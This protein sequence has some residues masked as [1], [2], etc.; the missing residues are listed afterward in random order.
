MKKLILLFAL[1]VSLLP[2]AAV[3][4]LDEAFPMTQSDG[5]VIMV[6]LFGEWRT[7]FYITTDGQ[8]LVRD[9]NK[10]LCY[11]RLEDGK[12]VSTGLMAHE[13][14]LRTQEER[15]FVVRNTLTPSLAATTVTPMHPAT[16]RHAPR[17]V[18]QASTS[19]GLGQYGVRSLGAVPSLGE[20][21]IPVIMVEFSD[22]KFQSYSTIEKMNR[23]YNEEGYADESGCV[24][25]V[26]DYFIAQSGGLFRPRFE[27]VSKLSLSRTAAYY[28]NNDN[29]RG[30]V[31][32]VRDAM[33]AATRLGVK[34]TNYVQDGAVPLVAVLYAGEGEATGGGDDTLWPCEYDVNTT[35]SGVHVN[36]LF[37]GNEM[38]HD[39]TI[40]GM[41]TFCHEFGHALGLPDFYV[42]DYGHNATTMGRWD[43]MCSG[44]YLPDSHARAPIGYTAYER[45]YMGWLDIP[46]LTEA[47]NIV[48][49]PYGSED[50][51]HAVLIRSN[52]DER[53]YFI[54]EHR[55][56]G[57]WYPSS[58][59]SGLFVSHVT[60]DAS[61]WRYNNL[62]NNADYLRMTYLSASG[63]KSGGN[64]SELFPGTSNAKTSITTTTTPALAL[65][66]GSRL[67]KPVYNITRE[68]DG[69][70]SFSYLDPDFVGRTVGD[71]VEAGGISYRF[72]TKAQ[73]EVKPRE[74]GSAYSGDLTIPEAYVDNT[75]RY[76]VAGVG[77]E[78]FAD[79]PQLT[80]L[81]LPTTLRSV[82]PDA[83]RRSPALQSVSISGENDRFV[84]L[85]GVLYTNS[86]MVTD[87][88]TAV[89]PVVEDNVFDFASNPWNL[90]VAT[91]SLKIDGGL[92]DEDLIVGRVTMTATTQDAD[93]KTLVYMLSSGGSTELRL[94]KGSDV[95]FT[96]P[97]DTRI[98]RIDFPANGWTAT[99]SVGTM[100]GTA[101]TGQA[102]S[103]KFD[104]TANSRLTTLHVTTVSR[105]DFKEAAL[106]YY[107][108]ARTGT[109]TVT[110]GVSRIG[111]Y[112]FEGTALTAVVLPD[113][114]LTL[115]ADALSSAAL[116]SITARRATPAVAE[117]DP[118]T[119]VDKHACTLIV[120]D[121][122]AD[123]YRSA[124]YWAAFFDPDG[125]SE[126]LPLV[127]R[128][129]STIYDL[130][131]RRL[132]REPQLGV[133]IRDGKKVVKSR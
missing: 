72:V 4:P 104:I 114:L 57:T 124:P 126:G 111:D 92:L 67:D 18:I 8:V 117:D 23:F 91:N 63:S 86:I 85:D 6:K 36:S 71:V 105:R 119:L 131:G 35:M 11:A 55:A 70:V 49:G 24:G 59:G 20:V 2:A 16:G 47:D 125:I 101:W 29:T 133:F 42:T 7:E 10:D 66:N 9:K 60:Y 82:A 89:T 65:S 121:G 106:L 84:T 113:S 78:A 13:K 116:R 77:S 115:G 62:N 80:S 127:N 68:K 75:H 37:I 100:D 43:I 74:D 112:A 25:S 87:P 21:V 130:Q 19:D 17:R 3:P 39:G 97:E 109:F 15:D 48:L 108:A 27:V 102:E 64:A 110:P 38:A 45:S 76:T 69:T 99:P 40:M 79:C 98:T 123:A 81:T 33:A 93:E 22:V 31:E 122:S 129:P 41:G 52:R 44:S 90:D 107:P 34:W 51:P 58:F 128:H 28:G 1:L 83:F 50:M 53:E 46:E 94:K 95:T 56:P 132:T 120:P 14:E 30:Y 12:L 73:V 54:L 26:R 103:V 61:A 32:V 88:G 96:V 5:S 118:F